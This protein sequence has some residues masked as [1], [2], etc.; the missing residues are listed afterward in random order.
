M[1]MFP[2]KNLAR[3]G[4]RTL[5]T[6]P[7]PTPPHPILFEIFANRR[8]MTADEYLALWWTHV[9]IIWDARMLFLCIKEV[10]MSKE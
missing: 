4:L 1:F 6:P 10:N 5:T 2:L 8:A 9:S 7:Q 3:K